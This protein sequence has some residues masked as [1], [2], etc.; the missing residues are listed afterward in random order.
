MILP[1]EE[2]WLL[3]NTKVFVQC[4]GLCCKRVAINDT[5]MDKPLR[6]MN[7]QAHDLIPVGLK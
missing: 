3:R 2:S 1:C 7:Q 4:S 5:L 6:C